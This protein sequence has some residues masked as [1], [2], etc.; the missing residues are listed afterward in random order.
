MR[1]GGKD[2]ER[3]GIDEELRVI[4]PLLRILLDEWWPTRV[5][6]IT[7]LWDCFHRRLEKPFLIQ[8]SGPW[9]ISIEK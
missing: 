5:Q 4:I 3:D 9:A 7:L 2:E 6:I 1:K 8:T